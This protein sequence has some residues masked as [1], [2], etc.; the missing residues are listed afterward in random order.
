VL[1]GAPVEVQTQDAAGA[2][3]TVATATIDANGDFD[4][5]LQ[6]VTATYRARIGATNGFAAGTTPP[7]SVVTARR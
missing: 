3:T 1:A 5:T 6:L 2:W 7:L 4:A